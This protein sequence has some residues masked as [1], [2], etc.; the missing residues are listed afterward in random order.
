MQKV[1]N[2]SICFTLFFLHWFLWRPAAAVGEDGNIRILIG[3][4]ACQSSSLQTV[5]CFTAYHPCEKL[6]ICIHFPPLI[7]DCVV[8][9]A[10]RV[11][12]PICPFHREL[13]P[14]HSG[15]SQCV[16]RQ[17]NWYNPSS[18]SWVCHS[19][20]FQ[21]WHAWN[22]PS[23]LSVVIKNPRVFFEKE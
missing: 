5:S 19:V 10:G 7:R 2:Q 21:V 8:V 3:Q 23:W 6:I 1:E 9:G 11:K 12:T 18:V 20:S 22:T 4:F 17:A 16:P 13:L 15:G 14:A